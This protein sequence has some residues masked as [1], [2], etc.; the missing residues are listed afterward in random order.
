MVPIL[1]YSIQ[2]IKSWRSQLVYAFVLYCLQLFTQPKH[3]PYE[4]EVSWIMFIHFGNLLLAAKF[5][6]KF[7]IVMLDL[8]KTYDRVDWGYLIFS[9]LYSS[10]QR[11][12]LVGW[13]LCP[14]YFY[15]M[16]S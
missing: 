9:S 3:V 12:V 8:E 10:T 5:K 7:A 15:Y 14:S 13:K 6:Q 11:R 4:K 2:F 1:P 16:I